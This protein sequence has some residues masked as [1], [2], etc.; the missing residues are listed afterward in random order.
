MISDSTKKISLQKSETSST[1]PKK[2]LFPAKFGAF[3]KTILAA[4]TKGTSLGSASPPPAKKI[5]LEPS[6]FQSLEASDS[7]NEYSDMPIYY[8]WNGKEQL[9]MAEQLRPQSVGMS[10]ENLVFD[11]VL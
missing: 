10:M 4:D 11:S 5:R 8:F 3:K 2:S 6:R 9:L 7:Q 1:T